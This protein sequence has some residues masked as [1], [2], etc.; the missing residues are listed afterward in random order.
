MIKKIALN[1]CVLFR[2]LETYLKG[3]NLFGGD[4]SESIYG[5]P[6]DEVCDHITSL[7]GDYSLSQSQKIHLGMIFQENINKHAQSRELTYPYSVS[8]ECL[9]IRAAHKRF[10]GNCLKLKKF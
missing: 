3:V 10:N 4:I 5:I 9:K 2:K 8:E 1:S 7:E 6:F